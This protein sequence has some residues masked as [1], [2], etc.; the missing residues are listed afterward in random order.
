MD[1][2]VLKPDTPEVASTEEVEVASPE[3]VTTE[4]ASTEVPE[5]ESSQ[6]PPKS[7]PRDDVRAALPP[8]LSGP[9]HR[10]LLIATALLVAVIG[11][12]LFLAPRGAPTR[13]SRT[14]PN[15]PDSTFLDLPIPELPEPPEPPRAGWFED[16]HRCPRTGAGSGS[17][18]PRPLPSRPRIPGRRPSAGPSVLPPFARR[19]RGVEGAGSSPSKGRPS[20]GEALS[21]TRRR[22]SPPPWRPPERASPSWGRRLACQ[23]CQS[24]HPPMTFQGRVPLPELR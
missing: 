1:E 22:P 15:L 16:P 13:E 10:N 6:A 23:V 3:A 20:E 4:T 19:R 14:A 5:P 21:S 18:R 12:S 8:A 2:K 17:R 7:E 11:L 24:C 9:N